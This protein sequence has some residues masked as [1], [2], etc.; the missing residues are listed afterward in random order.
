V[1]RKSYSGDEGWKT[2]NL[3]DLEPTDFAIWRAPRLRPRRLDGRKNLIMISIDTLR[4]DHLHFMGYRRETSPNLDRLAAQGVVF[5]ECIAQAPWTTPS[6]Y[7][8]LTGTYPSTNGAD[9][10]FVD[11]MQGAPPRWNERI[12]TLAMILREKGYETA[13]FTGMGPIS[14]SFGFY[15]GFDSYNETQGA[16]TGDPTSQQVG[17]SDAQEIVAKTMSWLRRNRDRSFFLFVHTFEVHKPYTDDFFV[18][19]EG[20]DPSDAM[21]SKIARYD[22]DIRYADEQ[23]GTLLAFLREYGLMDQTLVVLVSDHGDEM[24]EA[25]RRGSVEFNGGHGHTL[26]D[27]LVHVP[28]V[29]HG[30]DGDHEGTRIG[31]QVRT[32]D[33]VPTILDDLGFAVPDTVQGQSLLPWV[34]GDE[35]GELVAFS[36]ATTYGPERVSLR[37]N[38]YKLVHRISYGDL[39]NFTSASLNLT[40]LFELYDLGKD[41]EETR[42]IAREHPDMVRELMKQID[43]IRGTHSEIE[44]PAHGEQTISRNPALMKSLRSLGYVQ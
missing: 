33:I 10:S 34:R 29:F 28:L 22:G 20:I 14:A 41:P 35:T 26:F 25:P 31:S 9:E 40:P 16:D 18:K 8:I 12:P 39:A 27:D 1:F 37:T 13:A 24:D 38:G 6:H 15:R 36:E 7:S 5:D 21:A 2:K 17:L 42:N 19:S 11:I 32:I 3:Y 44:Q 30:L 4:A 43:A 23:I